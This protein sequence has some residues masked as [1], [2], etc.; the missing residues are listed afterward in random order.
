MTVEDF[1][2]QYPMVP[3]HEYYSAYNC[4]PWN[5]ECDRGKAYM[6]GWFDRA[7][8]FHMFTKDGDLK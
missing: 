6:Q 5:P 2:E 8:S 7:A 4:C 3:D 1:R